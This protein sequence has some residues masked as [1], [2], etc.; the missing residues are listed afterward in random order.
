MPMTLVGTNKTITGLDDKGRMKFLVRLNREEAQKLVEA[1]QALAGE[2]QIAL[3]IR[4]SEKSSKNGG[5]FQS[6][7]IMVR[8]YGVGTAGTSAGT[9]G[10]ATGPKKAFAPKAKVQAPAAQ[11]QAARIKAEVE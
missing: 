2:E 6:S 4:T 3:D 11:S 9:S 5:N 7:F 10:Y 8:D 1:V